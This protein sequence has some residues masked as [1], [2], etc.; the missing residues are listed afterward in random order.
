MEAREKIKELLMEVMRELGVNAE[1]KLE[2]PAEEEHGDYS[3]NIAMTM[4]GNFKFEILNLKL[5][6]PLEFAKAIVEQLEKNEELKDYIEKIEVAQ[7]GFINFWLSKDALCQEMSL[8]LEKGE[9][10]GSSDLG[11]GKT[12]VID[13]SAPNVAK[14]FGI[15]HL[16][17]TI[18][19]QA[20]YNLYNFLGWQTI[21]DNHLGDWGTQ[22]GT[23]LYQITDKN[24]DPDTLDI[25]KL[26][27]LYVEFNTKA[28]ENPDL[29]EEA[30]L[31]FKKLEDGDVQARDIWKKV[32]DTSLQEYGRIYK[33]LGVEIDFAHGESFYE[34]MLDG[35]IEEYEQKGIAAEDQGA[36]VIH[37]PNEEMTPAI[38]RKSDG[39]STYLTRDLATIEYRQNEW[40][41]DLIAYEV[42]AEQSLHFQQVFTAYRLLHPEDTT[43]FVHIKHGLYLSPSGKKFSTRRGDIVRLEEVL[44][45]AIERAQKLAHGE[46]GQA[47]AV[48]IGAIKYFDLSHHPE[49]NII[50]DWEKMFV[51]EGNSAPYLQYTYARTESVLGKSGDQVIR[52]P[53]DQETWQPE[54]LEP[55]ELNVLKWIYRFPEV[56]EEAA[57]NFAPN[58]VCTY[59]FELAQ[60]YNTFYNKHRI[61]GNQVIGESGNQV[62]GEPGGR[63]TRQPDNPTQAFR[64][65]L[66]LATGIILKTGLHLLGIQAPARM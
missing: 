58:T 2:H 45:E 46:D 5:N 57:L 62:A 61:L 65:A 49:S 52:K 50:F 55:E 3:S 1:V 56:V 21:G 28:Q 60:R 12:M 33:L 43:K 9:R 23:L 11:K 16:R 54:N 15:G 8:V 41:P 32:K 40:K 34:K 39:A 35:I 27:E 26:Q 36:L 42:G 22:F 4:F 51:L 7:P 13:Y 44:E 14:P 30:R 53:G 31:W 47:K 37:F 18:I 19:G 17:S 25:E 66:T 6:S 10:Y 48:G 38:L 29:K 64:L 63:G 20:L 59:L 24:L